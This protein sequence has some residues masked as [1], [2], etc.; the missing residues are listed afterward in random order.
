MGGWGVLIKETASDFRLDSIDAC[1]FLSFSAFA[2]GFESVKYE[3][4]VKLQL[5]FD[6]VI[7]S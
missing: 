7:Y 1:D 5:H 2:L 3:V 4:C 6:L